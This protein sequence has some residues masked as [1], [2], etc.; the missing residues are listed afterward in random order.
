M[1]CKKA[2]FYLSGYMK[3][4]LGVRLTRRIDSHLRECPA[5]QA[6]LEFHSRLDHELAQSVETP[7]EP[8]ERAIAMY[9]NDSLPPRPWLAEKLGDAKL[10]RT[11]LSTSGAI[12]IVVA[13]F[14]MAPVFATADSAHDTFRTMKQAMAHHKQGVTLIVTATKTPN[15]ETEI[16]ASGPAGS[17]PNGVNARVTATMSGNKLTATVDID[18]DE[19]HY[20][21]IAF[22]SNKDV[23]LLVPKG[24]AGKRYEVAVDDR[25]KLPKTWSRFAWDASSNKYRPEAT[26]KFVAK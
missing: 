26:Y 5:C 23:L 2:Q 25:S 16:K 20:K 11:F 21:S 10:R 3:G 4:E 7:K 9:M 12:A 6:S 8:L 22:G 14:A 15:G 1:E 18:L 13:A 24:V 17:S 19:S